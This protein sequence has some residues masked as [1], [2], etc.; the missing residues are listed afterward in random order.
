MK[1]VK[2]QIYSYLGFLLIT[3]QSCSYDNETD[4]YG[5][6]TCDSANP[7]YKTNIEPLINQNCL[8][9]HGSGG[10]SGGVNL[11]SYELVKMQIDKGKLIPSV[12]QL[13]GYYAMPPSNKLSPCDIGQLDNWIRNGMPE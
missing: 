6:K 12:K 8:G 2:K 3:I 10:S 7:T 1:K 9:C 4:K 11:G 13:P 5:A